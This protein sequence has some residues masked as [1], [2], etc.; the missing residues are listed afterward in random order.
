MCDVNHRSLRKMG[1]KIFQLEENRFLNGAGGG[2]QMGQNP[3]NNQYGRGGGGE[4][5]QTRQNQ[6]KIIFFH[7][8]FSK[9]SFNNKLNYCD[10]HLERKVVVKHRALL[11]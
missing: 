7:V 2:E 6:I 9:T 3:Y 4:G 5:E 11:S 8:S 1:D 10:I